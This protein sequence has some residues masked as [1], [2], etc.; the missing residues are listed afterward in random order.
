MEFKPPKGLSLTGDVAQNWKI[1]SQKF[2]IF[3]NANEFTQKSDDVKIAMLLNAVGDEGL[4][5][6]NTFGLTEQQKKNYKNVIQ[7]FETYCTPRKSTV[8]N[9]YKF[10]MRSQQVGES[11]D[12]YQIELKHLAQNCEF[13]GQ[14]DSLI[15][16]R[17][18]IGVQDSVLQERLLREVDLSLKR[19]VEI[20]QAYEASK[21]EA[22]TIQQPS[23]SLS[24]SSDV[25]LLKYDRKKPVEGEKFKFNCRNCKNLHGVNECPAYGKKCLGCGKLNHFKVACKSSGKS[26]FKPS[27]NRSRKSTYK[28]VHQLDTEHETASENFEHSFSINKLTINSVKNQWCH[29]LVINEVP[30]SF[31]MDSGSDINVLPYNN[32]LEICPDARVKLQ[33]FSHKVKAYGGIEMDVKGLV[34]LECK[35]ENRS[36]VRLEFIVIDSESQPLLSLDTCISLDLITRNV[37]EMSTET[38]SATDKK[39]FIQKNCTVFTGLGKIPF[40]YKIRLKKEAVPVVKPVRRVPETIKPK[41]KQTLDR[42]EK[43]GII[44]KVTIPTDWVNDLIIVEKRDGSLR[45][46][47]SPLELNKYIKR[48]VFQIPTIEDLTANLSGKSLYTVLDMK[49]GFFQIPL[50]QSST[51]LCVFNT[52]FGRYKME[53]LPFGLSSSPEIFQRENMKIFSD[54]PGVQVYF[55]DI[56]VAA[57]TEEEHDRILNTVVKRALEYGVR[58]NP[59]KLQYKVSSVNYLGLVFSNDGLQPDKKHVESIMSI[60]EP[61]N[62]KS[63][64]KFLGVITFLHKFIPHMSTVAAPLR[65]LLKKDALWCWNTEHQNAFDN[66][67]KLVSNA[68]TLKFFDPSEQIVVQSD[69]SKDGLG[70]CLLQKGRPVAFVSRS[71]TAAEK[72]YSMVEKELL[73]ICF[74]VRKFHQFIYG[75]DIICET[76]HKPLVS[77]VRKDIHKCTNRIQRLLLKLLIYRLDV[78]YLPGSFMYISDFLSR[79]FVTDNVTDDPDMYDVVHTVMLEDYLPISKEKL[80]VFR[81][82]TG[83]DPILRQVLECLHND[84]WDI[85]KN[86]NLTS[87]YSV[88]HYHKIRDQLHTKNGILFVNDKIVVPS[89]LYADMLTQIHGEAHLGVVK[90]KIRAR[91][92]LYWPGMSTMI[93]NFVKKCNVC[94]KYQRS[95]SKEPLISHEIPELPFYKIAIDIAEYAG[96]SY[97]IVVDYLSKWLEIILLKNKTADEIIFC[98]K[99]LFST[100]G[101]PKYIVCDNNPF[102]SYKFEN[103]ANDYNFEIIHSSPHYHQSNGLCER[104]VG[105][106]KGILKKCNDRKDIYAALLEYRSS[107]VSGLKLSPAEILMGRSLRTNIPT[108]VDHL[109]PKLVYKDARKQLVNN[110]TQI[111]NYYD[112]S[113]KSRSPFIPGQ[114]I[115]LQNP[116]TKQWEHGKIVNVN[117]TPRSYFVKNESDRTYVRN[118][119]FLRRSLNEPVIRKDQLDDVIPTK[120][121]NSARLS[122]SSLGVNVAIPNVSNSSSMA[123]GHCK[124]KS[125]RVTS[126]PLKYKDYQL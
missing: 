81:N 39:Y 28:K 99:V 66:L 116:R 56:I 38:T 102:N 73:G 23:S 7:A 58:F 37:D 78:R 15:R 122:R 47:L 10:F 11:F 34:S 64:Q 5:L 14:S 95:N 12:H 26:N 75:H 57:S 110:Q 33:P 120:N 117:K 1:F 65:D 55:D 32:Y 87:E 88:K 16:D 18:I 77:I 109:K 98:L 36:P 72:R 4:Q 21:N 48:E 126:M 67:K 9:R 43:A 40:H 89:S 113:A 41:L 35:P 70:A 114:N 2:T 69:A 25:N 84:D 115:T 83:N 20:C 92:L 80:H 59:I 121:G 111:K 60:K 101:I 8:L 108:V 74:A 68:P 17:I 107:P 105:I 3:L 22:K 27:A 62:K 13:E 51:Y 50:E 103:F 44:S 46:C 61:Q 123:E 71:L 42:M 53:R 94:E 112:Q 118:S 119:S 49:D 124:T 85:A 6:Y 19:T 125:G 90:S 86:C 63:L 45:L 100:H 76:D 31:K 52:P 54:I 29:T 106:A 96:D 79:N 82:E 30:V 97:L 104:G 24:A 91:K 93:D